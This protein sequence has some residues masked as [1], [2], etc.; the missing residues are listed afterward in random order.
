MQAREKHKNIDV[1][2][3]SFTPLKNTVSGKKEKSY[4][5]MI[6][7]SD[8]EKVLGIHM[9]GDDAPEIIQG[10]AIPVNMGAKKTDFD[11]VFAIHPTSAEEIVLLKNKKLLN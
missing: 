10:F 6:T 7:N 2:E 11:K 9:I 5:R 3:S 4:I 1:Y 8:T